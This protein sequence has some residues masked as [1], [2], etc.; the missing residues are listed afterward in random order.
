MTGPL[1]NP[2]QPRRNIGWWTD[3]RTEQLKQLWGDGLS[4]REIADTMG[5]GSRSGVLGKVHRLRL[6]GRVTQAR[7]AIKP[8]ERPK[9]RRQ[10]VRTLVPSGCS[11]QTAAW[12]EKARQSSIRVIAERAT[13]DA[14]I[15]VAGGMSLFD[16]EP[17]KCRWP[18]TEVSPI[19]QFR[20]CGVMAREGSYC[21]EH[22]TRSISG[23]GFRAE[24]AE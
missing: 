9:G 7:A 5:A 4:A 24:A 22:H 16:I 8:K 17:G 1:N 21:R 12:A 20:F 2:C 14:L 18:M 19:A 10:S 13:A 11:P 15:A 3:E 6:P 23:R